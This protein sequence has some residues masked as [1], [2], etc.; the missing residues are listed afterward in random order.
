MAATARR[1]GCGGAKGLVYGMAV[2]KSAMQRVVTG[3]DQDE[4]GHWRAQLACGHAI[5]VRHDPPWTL[6][7]WVLD[8]EQRAQRIGSV[9]NC[10]RCGHDVQQPG[11][12]MRH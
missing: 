9:M 6:R 2:A 7:T 1:F 11:L 10:K 4:F 12:A 3:F 8:P 5:H